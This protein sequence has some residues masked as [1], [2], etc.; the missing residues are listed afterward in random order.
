MKVELHR[1][2]I[3]L[4]KVRVH[5]DPDEADHGHD[6]AREACLLGQN[7]ELGQLHEVQRRGA[8]R[9]SGV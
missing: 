7:L 6:R 5:G 1:F 9:F 8:Y 2:G 3:D 4:L